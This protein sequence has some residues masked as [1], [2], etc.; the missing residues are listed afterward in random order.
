M[1]KRQGK[2]LAPK[3]CRHRKSKSASA[4]LERVVCDKCGHVSVRYLG[5]VIEDDI[6]I[7]DEPQVETG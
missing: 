1:W 4:G 5:A 3:T 7:P 2:H 6:Y